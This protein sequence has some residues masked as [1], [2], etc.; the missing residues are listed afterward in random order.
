MSNDQ[1]EK[2]YIIER[3]YCATVGGV[4]R[5]EINGVTS[6]EDAIQ[7]AEETED[8]THITTKEDITHEEQWQQVKD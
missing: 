5:A 4:D 3:K 7:V 1:E 8:Y 2:V 6:L